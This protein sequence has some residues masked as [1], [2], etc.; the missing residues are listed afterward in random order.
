MASTEHIDRLILNERRA[1]S[2]YWGWFGVVVLIGVGLIV[3]N[4]RLGWLKEVGPAIRSAFVLLLA[5]PPLSEALKRWDRL[6]ALRTLKVSLSQ[7]SPA[8]PVRASVDTAVWGM[9]Q[10]MLEG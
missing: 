5:K 8:D 7:T 10:K 3:V 1:I 2:W 4:L 9:L 6:T